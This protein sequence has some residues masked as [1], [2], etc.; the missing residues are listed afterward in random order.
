MTP[1]DWETLISYNP[2]S[3]RYAPANSG[4]RTRPSSTC[5]FSPSSFFLNGQFNTRWLPISTTPPIT[6][7]PTATPVFVLYD[8][9]NPI[10]AGAY[11]KVYEAIS[12]HYVN[13]RLVLRVSS[14]KPPRCDLF[15]F[16]GLLAH[17]A[18]QNKRA[19]SALFLRAEMDLAQYIRNKGP[20]RCLPAIDETDIWRISI[21]TTFAL[22]YLHDRDTAHLDVKPANFMCRADGTIIMADPDMAESGIGNHADHIKGTPSYLN[23]RKD[24]LTKEDQDAFALRRTLHLPKKFE[25]VYHAVD[26]KLVPGVLARS[27]IPDKSSLCW[28]IPDEFFNNRPYLQEILSAVYHIEAIYPNV[29]EILC[30]LLL[31]RHNLFEIFARK[32]S[33]INDEYRILPPDLTTVILIYHADHPECELLTEPTIRQAIEAIAQNALS[34]EIVEDQINHLENLL[35]S[36]PSSPSSDANISLDENK[37]PRQTMTALI[38]NDFPGL[39]L[40]GLIRSEAQAANSNVLRFIPE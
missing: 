33:T 15:S 28:V 4:A 14:E 12:P 10:G 23:P 5:S 36:P 40:F 35:L 13:L 38:A 18:R 27:Q 34:P 7:A 9:S 24:S 22:L 32:G 1:S 16:E 3:Y 37:T 29:A 11:A 31:A 17:D 8:E 20:S 39:R 19:Y 25:V 2:S 26:N 30:A 6:P 21:N